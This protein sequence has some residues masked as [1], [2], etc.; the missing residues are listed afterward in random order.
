MYLIML[1][2]SDTTLKVLDHGR[3]LSDTTLR[4]SDNSRRLSDTALRVLDHLAVSDG[5]VRYLNH[6]SNNYYLIIKAFGYNPKRNPKSERNQQIE[7]SV[8]HFLLSYRFL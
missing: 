6:V 8:S 7:E 5:S 4:V 3:R 1:R 2:L